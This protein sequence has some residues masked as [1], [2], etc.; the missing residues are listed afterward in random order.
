M[1]G[2]LCK[3]KA[4]VKPSGKYP[5][6]VGNTLARLGSLVTRYTADGL[7]YR[8]WEVPVSDLRVSQQ[9]LNSAVYLYPSVEAA[10]DGIQAGGS[11]FLVFVPETEKR[12]LH[13]YVVTNKHVLDKGAHVI[14]MNTKDGRTR[15]IPT[16]PEAWTVSVE[17]DLAVMLLDELDESFVWWAISSEDFVTPERLA[18][19]QIDAGAEVLMIGR[20]VTHEGRVKNKPTVRFGNIAMMADPDE[21][22]TLGTGQQQEAFLVDCRSLSGFSGS[23]VM[24]APVMPPRPPGRE[25]G[26]WLPEFTRTM[27]LGVDCAHAPLWRTVV[28]RDLKTPT[29]YRVDGNTGIAV[30]VPAWRLMALLNQEHLVEQRKREDAAMAQRLEQANRAV[31]DSADED[32]VTPFTKRDF[33]DALRKVSRKLSDSE[34]P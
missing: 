11:G 25:K 10:R 5:L 33:D 15:A 13:L 27:L 2:I 22:V 6:T 32:K 1:R 9:A 24:M 17:D 20:L 29:Q 3:G 4:K 30:V 14:R 31:A 26:F 23:A 21:P 7:R 18:E 28:E 8:I 16:Q 12:W 19:L 34:K